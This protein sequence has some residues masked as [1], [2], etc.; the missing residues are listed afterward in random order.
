MSVEAMSRDSG[1][2]AATS[3]YVLGFARGLSTCTCILACTIH[4]HTTPYGLF[5]KGSNSSWTTNAFVSWSRPPAPVKGCC[6]G[7]PE[8]EETRTNSMTILDSFS[9][10][11]FEGRRRVPP[12]GP[13]AGDTVR[14]YK[15]AVLSPLSSP[16]AGIVRDSMHRHASITRGTGALLADWTLQPRFVCDMEEDN[17]KHSYRSHP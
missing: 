4:M 17:V 12:I 14:V 15:K 13:S 16:D 3:W 11:Y 8:G 7:H 9:S 10:F 1:P 6:L 5:H 2:V